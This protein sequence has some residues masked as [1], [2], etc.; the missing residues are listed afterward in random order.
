MTRKR[1]NSGFWECMTVTESGCWEWRG[2]H[3]DNVA[4]RIER[5]RS[6]YN[7]AKGEA[8]PAAKLT[9]ADVMAIRNRYA[10]GDITQT[11]LANEYRVTQAVIWRVV[12]HTKWRH[13]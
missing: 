4:D 12:H 1:R 5:G 9:V 10:V 3:A 6:N 7:Q 11:Q 8:N 2:T 13:V